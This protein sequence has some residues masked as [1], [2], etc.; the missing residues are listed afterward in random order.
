MPNS[1]STTSWS[2]CWGSAQVGKRIN[3]IIRQEDILKA[4]MKTL[5][6]HTWG[7]CTEVLRA[8]IQ[9]VPGFEDVSHEADSQKLLVLLKK[10]SYN[11]Q[12]QMNPVQDKHKAKWHF[13]QLMQHPT[14]HS[15]IS[16]T[17]L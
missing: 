11:F 6:S 14:K 8:K 9:A 2:R 16:S 12:S 10:E 1:H 13:Y 5:F 7:Q 4:N 3:G 15:M 17:T